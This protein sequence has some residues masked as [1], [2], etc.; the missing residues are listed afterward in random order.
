MRCVVE[1]IPISNRTVCTVDWRIFGS[2]QLDDLRKM[3]HLPEPEKQYNNAFLE[4]FANENELE[5]TPIKRWRHNPE[6]H[7]HKSSGKYSV[8][9]LASP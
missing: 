7:K 9:S 4:K 8:D 6:K 5:S 3:C 1:E 2:F